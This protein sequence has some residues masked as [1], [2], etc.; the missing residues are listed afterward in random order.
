MLNRAFKI[1]SGL[2]CFWEQAVDFIFLPIDKKNIRRSIGIKFI[3]FRRNRWGGKISY[4]EWAHVIGIFQV[5]LF[6]N[7]S[8]KVIPR[9]LDIGCGRGLVPISAIPLLINKGKLIGVDVIYKNISFCK[10]QFKL[11]DMEFDFLDSHNAAYSNHTVNR[12][13][14]K[15]SKESFNLITALS[16]W[17]HLNKSD[18]VFYLKEAN[19]VLV[20]GGK[21]IMTCFLI[22]DKYDSS[23]M[24]SKDKSLY[25]SGKPK[26]LIFNRNIDD[27]YEWFTTEKADPPEQLIAITKQGILW[28]LSQANF[29][30]EEHYQG[31]WKETNGLYFQDILILS[32]PR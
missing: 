19:R 10:D 2:I 7:M 26:D 16:V 8:S 31:N 11:C 5:L 30:L 17:T 28:L 6:Q 21:F 12:A 32:K 14:L 1:W 23:K 20:R 3:P 13:H 27:S 15:Y 29:K 18:A 25:H 4:A 22:D 9:I 24:I